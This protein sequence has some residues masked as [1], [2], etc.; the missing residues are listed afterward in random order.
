MIQ[1]HIQNYFKSL[2]TLLAKL[3]KLQKTLIRKVS[4]S[5][6]CLENPAGPIQCPH[7][8]KAVP[9]VAGRLRVE[10]LVSPAKSPVFIFP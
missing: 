4:R 8:H 9:A 3:T 10:L 6:D 2:K 7:A 1:W 5:P